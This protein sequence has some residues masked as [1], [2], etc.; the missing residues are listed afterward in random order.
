MALRSPS[1]QLVVPGAADRAS[2]YSLLGLP[3]RRLG[4]SRC[5]QGSPSSAPM[6]ANPPRCM[7]DASWVQGWASGSRA[8]AWT[9]R[10]RRRSLSPQLQTNRRFSSSTRPPSA[11]IGSCKPSLSQPWI[12]PP[13][14]QQ[15]PCQCRP[16]RR[17]RRECRPCRQCRQQRRVAPCWAR[18]Q[19]R[20]ARQLVRSAR[21]AWLWKRRMLP[22][23]T[24]LLRRPR[25]RPRQGQSSSR[26]WTLRSARSPPRSILPG[27]W[28]H[29]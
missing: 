21:G 8:A 18:R 9:E 6:A 7:A 13:P 25:R 19:Q 3:R 10:A 16:H 29:S 11:A 22:K 27:V 5:T 2:R 14:R 28:L 4:R 17:C 12:R 26:L 20:A 15:P 23:P 24:G 1:S